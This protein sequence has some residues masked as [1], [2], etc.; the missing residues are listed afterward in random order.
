MNDSFEAV[1]VRVRTPKSQAD[2][3]VY[4]SRVICKET[5]A[6]SVSEIFSKGTLC[7]WLIFVI[8]HNSE[9][10][11]HDPKLGYEWIVK[12]RVCKTL[13]FGRENQLSYD[14][15][16]VNGAERCGAKKVSNYGHNRM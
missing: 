3:N 7:V 8:R 13:S 11:S 9:I 15:K 12:F 1:G 16:H 5:F 14:R 2:L 4:D 6:F 10:P